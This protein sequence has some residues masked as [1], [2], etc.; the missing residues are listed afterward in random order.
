MVANNATHNYPLPCINYHLTLHSPVKTCTFYP[1]WGGIL[2]ILFLVSNGTR[3][4]MIWDL[5][6]QFYLKL[7]GNPLC[8]NSKLSS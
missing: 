5:L 4:A 7:Y 1:F 8:Y 2:S 3:V 6:L